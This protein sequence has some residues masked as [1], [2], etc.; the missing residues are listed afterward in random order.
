MPTKLKSSQLRG[1]VL[2]VHAAPPLCEGALRDDTKNGREAHLW[3]HGRRSMLTV[4]LN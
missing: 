1:H 4:L 3:Y 2:C